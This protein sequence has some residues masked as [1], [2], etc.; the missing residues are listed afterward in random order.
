MES[1]ENKIKNLHDLTFL[2]DGNFTQ[3][4]EIVKRIS[5]QIMEFNIEKSIKSLV[6]YVKNIKFSDIRKNVDFRKRTASDIIKSEYVTGCTD[7]ALVFAAIS[8]QLK[9]PAKYVETFEEDWLEH[10]SLEYVQGHVFID[11][12]IENSWKIYDPIK[13]PRLYNE[14]ITNG[15]HYTVIGKGLDFSELYLKKLDGGYESTAICID[16]VDLM[17]GSAEKFMKK[18][19]LQKMSDFKI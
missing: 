13:G 2:E 8:R 19:K 14:Y 18:L 3:K 10:G 4:D 12:K 9:I 6:D 11:L 16:N 17:K 1:K 7:N 5:E 15:K